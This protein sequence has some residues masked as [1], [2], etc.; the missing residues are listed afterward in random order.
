MASFLK[1]ILLLFILLIAGITL[2][3]Q[4][5]SKAYRGFLNMMLSDKYPQISVDSLAKKY[6]HY[7]V[8]DAR[9][10][11]EFEVSHLKNARFVGYKN[12]EITAVNDLSKSTPIAIYCSVGKRSETV[13]KKLMKAGYNNVY[14]LY[15]GIFEW[16]NQGHAVYDLQGNLTEKVHAYSRFWGIWLNKGEKVY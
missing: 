4:V 16:V 15:G 6:T 8:L 13:E 9:E 2:F 7:I 14:N 1:W 10:R 12:F 5:K 11:D 3:P